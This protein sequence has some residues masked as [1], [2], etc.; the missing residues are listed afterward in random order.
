LRLWAITI[1]KMVWGVYLLLTSIYC[2]VAFLPYTYFALIK[3]PP[4]EWIPWVA[5]QQAVLYWIALLSA[6][7]AVRLHS[8][9]KRRSGYVAVFALLMLAGIYLTERPFLPSIQNNWIAYEW[10]LIALLPLLLLAGLDVIQHW[11]AS[12]RGHSASHYPY[13]TAAAIAVVVALLYKIGAATHNYLET[14]SLFFSRAGA[15]LTAWSILSHVLIAILVLSVLNLILTLSCRTRRPASFT[16]AAIVLLVFA[17]LWTMLAHFLDSALSFDGWA[18]HLYAASLAAAM[19][20]FGV[21]LVLPLLSTF[22]ARNKPRNF[23]LAAVAIGFSVFAI[24][25][26]TLISGSDWNGLLQHSFALLLWIT[27]SVCAYSL[28][29]RRADYSVATIL[30]VLLLAGFTYKALQSTEIFWGRP[31]GSTD[32]DVARA[33]QTYAA[34]DASFELTHYMLGNIHEED[35]GD[36]CRILRQYTNIRDA[37]VKTDLQ[38]VDQLTPA[39]GARPNIFFFVIDSLRPD[40]LGAYNPQVDFTPNLDAFA[41]DSDVIHNVYTQYAGTSLSEPAIWTGAMLLHAHYMQPFAKVNSLEKLARADGYKLVVSYDEVLSQLLSPSDDLVKL[42]TDKK[43]WNQIEVCS[44]IQQTEALLAGGL[45]KTQPI[46]FYSQPKNVHQF[47]SNHLPRMTAANW[48]IR[49]A[50]NNR[51][52]YEVHQVDGCLGGFFTFLKARGLYDNSLIILTSDHGDATGEFGRTS[53]SLSIY[54]EVMRVPLIVHLPRQM[55]A[56]FL[57][58]DTH[59]SALTDITPSIYYLL[60]HRPLRADPI[61]GQSLFVESMPGQR[62]L[63]DGRPFNSREDLARNRRDELFMASDERAVYGLLTENGRFLYATYDSPAQ[64]FLFDLTQDPNAQRSIVTPALKQEYDE[65]IIEHLH[66]LGD[67]Y[68]YKPGVGSLLAT[69]R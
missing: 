9:G 16:L 21:S 66:A 31:L 40:Y 62:R 22:P 68:G 60:G 24:A 27:L 28:W 45:G 3:G 46:L 17:A 63:A 69:T 32:D 51:I 49:P 5:H 38:L 34:Q 37:E 25:L 1:L 48:R 43:V 59:L 56:R 7:L 13:P 12:Q 4:Y 55:Q 29:P 2:L 52:A 57:Y 65:R 14:Q 26:P 61:L 19:T 53:H 67:F 23:A 33:L 50:F 8:P 58:D 41:R 64:S 30:G 18:A 54:P 44:T 20:L 36:L 6:A 35:C 39:S 10:S 11:P 47:A 42:D 15:E